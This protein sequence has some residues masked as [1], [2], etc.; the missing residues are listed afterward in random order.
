MDYV[1]NRGSVGLMHLPNVNSL[2][3]LS[4]K[5]SGLVGDWELAVSQ[6]MAIPLIRWIQVLDGEH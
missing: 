1:R 4:I 3:I 2:T 6:F 5:V